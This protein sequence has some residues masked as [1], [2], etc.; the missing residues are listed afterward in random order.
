MIKWIKSL[1]LL[2]FLFGGFSS[3]I[4]ATPVKPPVATALTTPGRLAVNILQTPTPLLAG[5]KYFLVYELYLTNFEKTPITL[6]NLEIKGPDKTDVPI[7]FAENELTTM[8]HVAGGSGAD[9]K[10]LTL[11]PG[12]T[13]LV[14]MWLPYDSFQKLPDSV[15]HKLSYV[16]PDK[17]TYA[18][19]LEPMAIHKNEPV[20]I[21]SPLAGDR[22]L[23]ANGPSN[24]SVHRR[25]GLPV[26]GHVYFAQRYAID[27][28][29]IGDNDLS[30]SGDK[31]KNKSFY[32]YGLDALAVSDGTV[33]A[34][35]D[36]I[37]ENIPNSGK[38]AIAPIT[39]ENVGGNYVVIDIGNGKYAYYAHL[40]PG[41][42]K[43]K[44]G[45]QVTRGQSIARVGNSGNS[46]EPHLHFHVVDKPTPVTANGVPF[47]FEEFKIYKSEVV[48]DKNESYKL[49]IAA[50]PPEH[51]TA[52]SVLEN[53][54][55]QLSSK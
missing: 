13:K 54:V 22:W 47:G 5:H 14:Y 52:Q 21:S 33:V 53:T 36:K 55:M 29:K 4:A 19:T 26:N 31:S 7:N 45:D 23:A 30:Y 12:M 9:P 8:T 50:T 44:V 24:T 40:I 48:P 20:L 2:A 27:F 3:A 41:S 38:L 49:N 42:L 1:I 25:A 39:V 51:V 16:S 10:P 17:Q 37:P 43:V 15:L 35:M 18:V 11:Q 34:V 6:T 28:I 32:C 46:S